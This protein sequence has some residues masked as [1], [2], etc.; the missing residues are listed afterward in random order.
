MCNRSEVSPAEMEL[1]DDK[2]VFTDINVKHELYSEDSEDNVHTEQ[3]Y[4]PLTCELCTET[5]SI[6]AEWVRHV[7][8][9]TDML[10]AKRQRRDRP[11]G[12]PV[13]ISCG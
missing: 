6:P 4:T 1:I 12:E 7:Q 2:E 13:S 10:P 9:H 8:T 5:F 11:D 3:L